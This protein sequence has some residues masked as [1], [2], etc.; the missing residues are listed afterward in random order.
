MHEQD[1]KFGT[2]RLALVFCGLAERGRYI[3]E[4]E[5]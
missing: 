5:V 1:R 4:R 2:L 3:S